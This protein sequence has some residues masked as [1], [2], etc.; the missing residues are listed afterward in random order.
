VTNQGPESWRGYES[1]ANA[2]PPL[3]VMKLPVKTLI[4]RRSQMPP[5]TIT[6]T[7]AMLCNSQA[8]LL[9]NPVPEWI[10][11]ASPRI[12]TILILLRRTITGCRELGETGPERTIQRREVVW[13]AGMIRHAEQPNLA[14]T[15]QLV[16]D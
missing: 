2:I 10:R 14:R 4:P 1:V 12:D 7:P 5:K 9:L 11:T 13:T 15:W 16:A 8:V 3:S 6:I